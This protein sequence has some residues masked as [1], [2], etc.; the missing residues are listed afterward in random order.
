[1]D[2]LSL[3][4]ATNAS[5]VVL[6]IGTA[7]SNSFRSAT[8]SPVCGFSARMNEIARASG[9]IGM[10]PKRASERYSSAILSRK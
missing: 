2:E 9:F 5:P 7:T 1:M 6:D 3:D 10:H 4:E 8:E